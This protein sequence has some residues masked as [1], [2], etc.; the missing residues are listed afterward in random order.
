MY[1]IHLGRTQEKGIAFWQTKSHAI[2]ANNTTPPDCIERVISHECIS[3]EVAGNCST[4]I[5][6]WLKD[7]AESLDVAEIPTAAEISHDSDPERPIKVASRKHGAHTH[8]PKDR[9][10]EI[11][12]R[13]KITTAPCRRRTGEKLPRA[14]KFGDLITADYK[15][16]NED[17]E[18]PN[19]YRYAVVVQ[20][21]AT[22]WIQSYPCKKKLLR[23]REGV[24]DSFSSRLKSQKSFTLTIRWNLVNSVKI[25]HGIIVFLHSIDPRWLGLPREQCA[26]QR[27]EHLPY[28]CNLAWMKNGGLFLWNA[29][30]ICEVFKISWQ[31]W[32]H[33]AKDDSENHLKDQKIPCGAMVEYHHLSAK[34][35]PRLHQI[36]K[37]V[38]PGIFLGYALVAEW[39]WKG[40]IMVA[41]IEELGK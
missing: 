6:E 1:W 27:K 22:Q 29:M 11:C 33:L 25:Y 28:C 23:W 31:M 3:Q 26:E 21:L 16:L 36:G 18:S 12:K 10:C 4:G 39:I 2:I 20:D 32:K 5:P 9:N 38:S 34:G 41:D 19:K 15:V 13:T 40:D 8:F 24:Y 30:A 35:Q 37:K 14:E 17:G 7:F